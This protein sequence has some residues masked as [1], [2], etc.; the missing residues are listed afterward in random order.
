M[1]A[2]RMVVSLIILMSALTSAR[3]QSVTITEPGVYAIGDLF[4]AAD[5]VALVKIVSGDTESYDHTVY[6]GEVIQS[7]KGM[8]HGATVYFGPY[9]GEKLGWEYVL[10]KLCTPETV[11]RWERPTLP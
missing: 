11:L 1:V 10:P 3:S 6:K 9:V 2:M 5:V 8:P 4:K 7:F